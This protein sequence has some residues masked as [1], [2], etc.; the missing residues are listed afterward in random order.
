MVE[1]VHAIERRGMY[2]HHFRITIFFILTNTKPS[3][4]PFLL[5]FKGVFMCFLKEKNSF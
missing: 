1:H 5:K 3:L 4:P 2:I